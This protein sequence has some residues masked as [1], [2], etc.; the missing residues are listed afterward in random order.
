MDLFNSGSDLFPVRLAIRRESRVR[1]MLVRHSVQKILATV[2]VV[3]LIAFAVIRVVLVDDTTPQG[4][5][6][7][8]HIAAGITWLDRHDYTL[9]SLHPPLARD[10]IALPLYLHGERFPRLNTQDSGSQSYCTELG[11]AILSDGGQYRRNLFLARVGILPFLC[12]TA[13]LVFVWANQEFGW[14]AACFAVF[15]FTTLPGVLAFSGL[16]YTDVVTMSTQFFCLFAFALWLKKPTKA[17]AF[18]LAIGTGLA[19][20]SKFTSFLFLPVACVGMLLVGLSFLRKST[21][22]RWPSGAAAAQL[23]A[24]LVIALII[25]W[26]SYRF[27]TGHLQ[28]ALALSPASM[29]FSAKGDTRNMGKVLTPADPVIPAPDLVRGLMIARLRNQERPGSYLFGS[30]KPGGSWYF[31]PLALA[32][33]TPLPFLILAVIGL[34]YAIRLGS[35]GQ[36][37]ALMPISAA[38]CIFLVTLFVTL[39]VGTRHVLIVLPLLSLLAGYAASRIWQLPGGSGTKMCA[40]LALCILLLWQAVGSIRAQDDLLAYFNELAPRD[41]SEALVKGCDLDCGQDLF[42]LSREL[43]ARGVKHVRLGIWT[44]AD[45][46]SVDLPPLDVLPPNTPVT[47]WIA[48]SLRGLRI[49]QFGFFQ[50]GRIVPEKG[51]PHDS[52]AWLRKYRPVA[53]IGKTILLYDIPENTSLAAQ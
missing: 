50:N 15:L 17:H 8:C 25:L 53:H 48:V 12:L 44:S 46:A 5:D 37:S 27:S 30:E 23:F 49:G 41:P 11:N 36:W 28:E 16:A 29:G 40:R 47:G 9:D 2:A 20:A 34:V 22:E 7:P 21:S 24:A 3:V 31:F 51:Y 19:F 18:L 45:L 1:E 32:L 35:Q 33:K 42:R 13:L 4:F 6:E 26:G 39:R 10:A 52:I 14:F 43:Q 38:G